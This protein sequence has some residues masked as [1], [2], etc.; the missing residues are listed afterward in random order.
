MFDLV[1][2]VFANQLLLLGCALVLYGLSK[3]NPQL[4][5]TR[6]FAHG[7][8]AGSGG[9]GLILLRA[10]TPAWLSILVANGLFVVA[11][12]LLRRGLSEVGAPGPRWWRW[13][14]VLLAAQTA[15]LAYYSYGR[16]DIDSRYVIVSL[17]MVAEMGLAWKRI[18]GV[19]NALLPWRGMRWSIASFGGFYFLRGAVSLW[20]L[21]DERAQ[22]TIEKIAA[23]GQMWFSVLFAVGILWVA[24]RERQAHLL[25]L[26]QQDA[27][28]GLL[29]RRALGEE[30][31]R[32][33]AASRAGGGPL[34]VIAV[35]L[36]HFKSIN[37][38][39]GHAAGD[40]ALCA[41][42]RVLEGGIGRGGAVARTGGEE[43]VV[44]LSGRNGRAAREEAERLRA[45]VGSTAVSAGE[46]R[47]ELTASFGVAELEAG[48][49]QDVGEAAE[50]LLRR[51]D[52]ALYSAKDGGRN[53][54]VLATAARTGG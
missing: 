42:A 21:G 28:T 15:G 6:W 35:D 8:L 16:P 50:A 10:Y 7:L 44:I 36:D 39:Y 17:M 13:D 30:L 20:W 24:T 26:S 2:F 41:V 14:M 53:R 37:D 47:L 27:L 38:R 9:L 3:R 51:A 46:E 34:A 19:D 29:S 5:G 11:F 48:D 1:T 33:V 4:K 52:R 23:G 43:F 49:T 18:A 45:L 31:D 32:A 22:A 54:S 12:A 25:Q 40:E